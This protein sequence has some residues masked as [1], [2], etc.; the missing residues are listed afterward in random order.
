MLMA[1]FLGQPVRRIYRLDLFLWDYVKSGVFQTRSAELQNR[2]LGIS[3]DSSFISRV[4]FSNG[5]SYEPSS[6]VLQ[7]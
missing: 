5:K 2:K 6:S 1:A 3:E 4:V 7:S